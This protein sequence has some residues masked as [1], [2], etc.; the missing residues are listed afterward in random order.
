M[1][2]PTTYESA[3][4]AAKTL[5]ASNSVKLE[6]YGLFKYISST[7]AGPSGSRPSAFKVEGR[8]KWDE[9]KRVALEFE[10]DSG[11]MVS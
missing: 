7:S 9:W 10:G 11:G 4:V 8:Y 5:E 3:L 6:L 2:L 1:D